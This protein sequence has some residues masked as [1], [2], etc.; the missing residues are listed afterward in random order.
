MEGI[1]EPLLF[2]VRGSERW[3][4]FRLLWICSGPDFRAADESSVNTDE[5]VQSASPRESKSPLDR[6]VGCEYS[7]RVF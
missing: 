7:R 4:T 2:V 3:A 1:G 5:G 6:Y